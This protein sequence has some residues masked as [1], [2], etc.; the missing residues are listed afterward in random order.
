MQRIMMIAITLLAGAAVADAQEPGRGG[1][2]AGMDRVTLEERVRPGDEIRFSVA[3]TPEPLSGR[4]ARISNDSLIIRM[5]GPRYW[6]LPIASLRD[7]QVKHGGGATTGMVIGGLLGAAVGLGTML[8]EL[9]KDCGEEFIP[10]L[11]ETGKGVAVLLPL[12]LGVAGGLLGRLVGGAVAPES[13]EDVPLRDATVS[14]IVDGK[15][16]ISIRVTFALD[17]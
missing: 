3:G 13:W 5:E 9:D 4:L 2:D 10:K 1:R 17:D 6:A 14:P 8:S 12:G 16:G 7:L 11:C 15:P